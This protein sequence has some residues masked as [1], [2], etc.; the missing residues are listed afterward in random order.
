MYSV[1][2]QE[3]GSPIID[4]LDDGRGVL[5]NRRFRDSCISVCVCVMTQAVS[6]CYAFVHVTDNTLPMRAHLLLYC[7][8]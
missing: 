3:Y 1:C 2:L 7:A 6:T 5:K 4:W 8:I